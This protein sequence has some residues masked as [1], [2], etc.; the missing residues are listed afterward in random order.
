MF[1]LP[2]GR[3]VLA[4][5]RQSVLCMG[6]VFD[7]VSISPPILYAD[8]GLSNPLSRRLMLC[9]DMFPFCV[10]LLLGYLMPF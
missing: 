2:A 7:A 5:L 3:L 8:G 4:S 9:R 6:A 1:R 10:A